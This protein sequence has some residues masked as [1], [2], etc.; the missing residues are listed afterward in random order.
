MAVGMDMVEQVSPMAIPTKENTNLI[1][2]M[3][4]VFTS[5]TMAA[6]TMACLVKTSATGR[7]ISS[8]PTELFTMENLSMANAKDMAR[9]RLVMEVNTMDPGRMVAMMDLEHVRGKMD[10]GIEENGGTAWPMAREPK[11]IRMG[12]FAMKDNGLMMNRFVK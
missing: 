1:N 12:M 11:H 7:E 2:G 3:D 9:I 10:V 6:F 4:V 5:G 8:G